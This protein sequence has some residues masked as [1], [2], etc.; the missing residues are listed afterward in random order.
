MN[1]SENRTYKR[2]QFFILAAVHEIQPVWVFN[3][4]NPGTAL[5]GLIVDMSEGGI[6]ILTGAD[7][8]PRNTQYKLK[9]L[10]DE[11][12]EGSAP[13]KLDEQFVSESNK[14]ESLDCRIQYV[15]SRSESGLHIRTGFTFIDPIEPRVLDLLNQISYGEQRYVRCSLEEVSMGSA[16]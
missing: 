6:Q 13:G 4:E 12:V 2:V 1:L 3:N 10:L 5:A 14:S 15:W 8:S 9:F 7:E 11:K 16:S